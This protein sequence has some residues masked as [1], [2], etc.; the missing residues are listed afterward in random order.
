MNENTHIGLDNPYFYGGDVMTT[1]IILCA[2]KY[3]DGRQ[4]DKPAQ[5]GS[6]FCNIHHS[7]LSITLANTATRMVCAHSQCYEPAEADSYFCKVH[8][9]SR[10]MKN[11]GFRMP[12]FDNPAQK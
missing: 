11:W 8:N 10:D 5:I 7:G 9:S 1:N 6:C 2:G 12:F 3:E 4:C